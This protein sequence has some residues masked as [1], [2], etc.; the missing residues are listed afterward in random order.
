MT[1]REQL[2]D[3]VFRLIHLTRSVMIMRALTAVDPN[4]HLNFWRLIQGN[5]LDI[6]VLEWCKVFGSDNEATHW[7]KI[8]PSADHNQFR[9]DLLVSAGIAAG[10]WT[11]YWKVMKRYRDNLQRTTM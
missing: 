7:K 2:I 9:N 8:V 6:A 4:P 10:E 5:Q 11:N 3:H 1:R